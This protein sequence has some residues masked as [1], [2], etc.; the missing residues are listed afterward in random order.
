MLM[1]FPVGGWLPFPG[2]KVKGSFWNFLPGKKD[3]FYLEDS[4]VVW[5]RVNGVREYLDANGERFRVY[6]TPNGDVVDGSGDNVPAAKG[7]PEGSVVP[8]VVVRKPAVRRMTLAETAEYIKEF[9]IRQLKLDSTDAKKVVRAY[10]K[11]FNESKGI[12]DLESFRKALENAEIAA[13]TINEIF[14]YRPWRALNQLGN[15]MIIFVGGLPV[16]GTW[17]EEEK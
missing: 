10:Q 17:K 5:R 15:K 4:G 14:L 6:T 2:K 7:K 13:E 11:S 9:A 8:E 3:T 12:I 16:P 1:M